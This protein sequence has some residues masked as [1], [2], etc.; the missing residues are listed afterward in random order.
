[1]TRRLFPRLLLALAPL[2][3]PP[4]L[5]D[6]DPPPPP[7]PVVLRHVL[8][9]LDQPTSIGNAGD[10]RLFLT[11]Q[12]GLVVLVDQGALRPEPFLDIR[13]L[14]T[15][16]GPGAHSGEQGLLGLAFHPRYAENGFFFVDYT[17]RLGAIV[18]ARYRASAAD[19]QQADPASGRILLTI[20]KP[21]VNHNGGQ[22]QF[23]PDGYLYVSIG[24]GGGSGGP[25]CWSQ[26]GDTLIGK[27]LRL[28]VDANVDTPP[29]HGIP[30]TNPFPGSPIWASGLRNA[31]R[32]SFDR[33]T[34]DLWIADVGQSAREEID[35][36]PAGTPGGRNYGWKLME[37]SACFSNASCPVGS[38]PCGSPD[39]TLPVLEYGH[40]DGECS[41]TGGYVARAPSL[42]HVW[43]A[44]FFGD[45]CSGRL[46]AA[47]AQG[48]AWRIRQLPQRLPGVDTFGEDG[49][50]NLFV[51]TH[52]GELFQLVPQL[53]VD[54]P[55]LFEPATARFLLKHLPQDGPEDLALRFGRPRQLGV[56]LAGDWDGDGHTGIGV[57]DAA[58]GVFRLKN[59]LRPGFADVLVALPPP[60]GHAIPLAGDWDGDGKDTV[61]FYDP[62]TSTFYLTNVLGGTGFPIV[63]QF[64]GGGLPVVGDWDG[65]GKDS[66]GL[67]VTGRGVFLLRNELSGGPP[68][69]RVRTGA[70]K[71][72]SLPLAGDWDGDGQDSVGLYEP[73][74]ATFRLL[75][76]E[77]KIFHFGT[78]G[79]GQLPLAGEW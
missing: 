22:L 38:P 51:A 71:G 33:Q 52:E 67:Y 1:M 77:E 4:V 79:A 53:P 49:A 74:T 56:P 35:V 31:W 18:V 64:G 8:G 9:G 43:G 3:P 72:S 2:L 65:D 46:W 50:G 55:G 47:D 48:G 63:F 62:T 17:D 7:A 30:P 73:A 42:P 13:S 37:G 39:L 25:E 69:L 26:K 10:G 32:F 36:Q 19:P 6:T 11:L 34:G 23:G 78:P 20:P 14:M 29:Y 27:L 5:F 54:T 15:Q 68:S 24:D 21:Y 75:G 70:R 40:D 58:A 45:L 66:V 16:S 76:P 12:G 61:G 44:Y 41:I 60:S 59:A 57:W 28:D